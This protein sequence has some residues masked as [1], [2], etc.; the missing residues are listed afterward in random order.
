MERL[1]MTSDDFTEAE[2]SLLSGAAMA[3]QK[4]VA[5]IYK[6]YQAYLQSIASLVGSPGDVFF[7]KVVAEL[8]RWRT[9]FA[10]HKRM[11][12]NMNAVAKS[13]NAGSPANLEEIE[14]IIVSIDRLVSDLQNRSF[15][16]AGAAGAGSAGKD[17]PQ[18]QR[19]AIDH[20]L[21]LRKAREEAERKE[22]EEMRAFQK[23]VEKHNATILKIMRTGA[24][25]IAKKRLESWPRKYP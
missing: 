25:E 19:T 20:A 11:A 10:N 14:S 8:G 17:P 4:T 2:K 12:S 16:A 9:I 22:I 13:G 18:E 24:A 5:D 15:R 6:Q 1:A 7:A 21:A 23:E 3:Q